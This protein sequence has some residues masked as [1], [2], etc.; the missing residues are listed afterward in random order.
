MVITLRQALAVYNRWVATAAPT[1]LLERGSLRAD[2]AQGLSE[3][4]LPSL[5]GLR[6]VAVF[7]V[8]FYH[9]GLPLVNGGLGVL[10]FFV[11]SGFLIT[12]LLLK[13]EARW[14][15]VSLRLFYVRRVLRIFPAFYVYWVLAVFGFW[16]LLGKHPL[17]PQAVASFLYVNNYYQAILGD[18]NT[19]L[20]H[21][22]SLGIEE[23]FYLLWPLSFILL[24]TNKRRIL[25]LASA[26][27]GV[28]VYRTMLVNVVGVPQGYI[29]EA[30]E[31]RADHLAIG[32]LLAVLLYERRLPY[33]F[34]TLTGHRFFIW[35]TIAALGTSSVAP[36]LMQHDYRDS[37]GFIVEPVLMAIL[38]VQAVSFRNTTAAWLNWRPVSYA[39]RISYSIY[40]YQQILI[41]PIKRLLSPFSAPVALL[42]AM[43]AVVL[44]ASASYYVVEKPFLALKGRLGQR[45]GR[46][47]P[48]AP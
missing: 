19:G 13:E 5:D 35:L 14:A 29:Y 10:M 9:F 36:F 45:H 34:N 37:I 1:G 27:L 38:I 3:S 6:A 43:A 30:F 15:A 33:L 26:I 11:I 8:V 21:T 23:Q 39:G 24:R 28:W 18:P 7:L 25:A 40:L 4:I 16:V 12:W 20:S 2:L 31:T 42:G 17:W 41:H 46:G 44:V 47:A 48:S 32:C 22:W